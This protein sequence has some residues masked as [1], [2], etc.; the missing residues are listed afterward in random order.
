MPVTFFLSGINSHLE[1]GMT[2]QVLVLF[3]DELKTSATLAHMGTRDMH[4]ISARTRA[5][6]I[7]GKY[8]ERGF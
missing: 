8:T 4:P 1:Y 6:D 2:F 5:T 7:A 3:V